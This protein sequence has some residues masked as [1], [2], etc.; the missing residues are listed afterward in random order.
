MEEQRKRLNKEDKFLRSIQ[1]Y[2][3][4]CRMYILLCRDNGQIWEAEKKGKKE[5]WEKEEEML[6]RKEERGIR[7]MCRVDEESSRGRKGEKGGMKREVRLRIWFF[8]YIM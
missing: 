5:E 7:K 1:I 2:I 8:S 3:I 6:Q 4:T